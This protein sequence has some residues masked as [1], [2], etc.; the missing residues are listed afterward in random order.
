M[1]RPEYPRKIDIF[2]HSITAFVKSSGHVIPRF[3]DI[4]GIG[5]Y[6]SMEKVRRRLS[7]SSR[8]Y[9]LR[10]SLFGRPDCF[11]HS[12]VKN[13]SLSLTVPLFRGKLYIS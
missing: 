4:S 9:C 7:F 5:A 13:F 2:Y 1:R 10:L 3:A 12:F 6:R 11:I 8:W